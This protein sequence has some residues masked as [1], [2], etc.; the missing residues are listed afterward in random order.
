MARKLYTLEQIIAMLRE[1]QVRL[2][3]QVKIIN[4]KWGNLC[5][6]AQLSRLTKSVLA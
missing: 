3:Q 6:E 2:S 1:A 5:E 4:A